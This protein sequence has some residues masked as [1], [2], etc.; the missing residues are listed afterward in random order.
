MTPSTP[1]ENF[2]PV[3]KE[4]RET[5][6]YFK[7]ENGEAIVVELNT[8]DFDLLNARF[9]AFKTR[10]EESTEE[11]GEVPVSTEPTT[12]PVEEKT[13]VTAPVAPETTETA[14]TEPTEPVAPVSE[15]VKADAP[16]N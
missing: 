2:Y 9:Q 1:V 5:S 15:E 8:P 14:P 16:Q 11:V 13:E 7:D 6:V 4:N 12:A 10:N 3:F